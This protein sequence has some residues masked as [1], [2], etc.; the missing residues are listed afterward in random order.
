MRNKKR[1]SKFD[2][3]LA[4]ED[5]KSNK[6]FFGAVVIASIAGFI[7]FGSSLI[8]MGK[9]LITSGKE[10]VVNEVGGV[11]DEVK[12]AIDV[13]HQTTSE[14]QNITGGLPSFDTSLTDVSAASEVQ[15]AASTPP[16]A[17]GQKI[18]V[19]AV[20]VVDGDTFII[21]IGG[22]DTRV[23]LIGVDT[24]ESVA[25][26]SYH[27]ENTEE[28]AKVSEIVKSYIKAGDTLYLE[29]D[30]GR[31]DT[32]GRTLA[33]LYFENGAMVQDWLLVNGYAQVMTIQPNSKYANHFVELEQ[34]AIAAKVGIW[35]E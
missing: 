2:Y 23:R 25:P 11:V 30:V 15:S 21:N 14:M 6:I 19:K 29:Y 28:G 35:R 3:F 4:D 18:E 32:Y 13:L 26:A 9:T 24:P 5:N 7:C 27:K 10:D 1:F 20:R 12:P 17:N 22:N 34:Q 31:T 16:A 33:Y 8:D